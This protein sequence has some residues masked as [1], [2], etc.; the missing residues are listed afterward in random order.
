MVRAGVRDGLA[1]REACLAVAART[2]VPPKTL[3][4]W[5]RDARWADEAPGRRVG[6]DRALLAPVAPRHAP[7]VTRAVAALALLLLGADTALKASL[8]TGSVAAFALLPAWFPQL[9][10]YPGAR[11]VLLVTVAAA[12]SGTVLAVFASD[13]HEVVA[14][15]GYG[16]VLRLFSIAAGL[17]VV[18]W[19]R[20]FLRLET[21]VLLY[22]TGSL[23]SGVLDIPGS[24]N[25]WKYQL[26]LPV[27]LIVLSLLQRLRSRLPSVAALLVLTLLLLGG[28]SAANDYR[29]FF[30]FTLLT[31]VLVTWQALRSTGGRVP[32][33]GFRAWTTSVLLVAGIVY[34]LYATV[35]SLLLS[36]ALGSELQA[37]SRVQVE[38]GGSLI[39]G[40]RPEWSATRVLMADSPGGYGV[41]VVPASRD[42]LLGKTGLATVGISPDN[43]YVDNYMFGG[44]FRLHSIVADCWANFGLVGLALTALVGFLLLNGLASALIE[45]RAQPVTVLLCLLALWDLAFGPI[46]SDLG[47]VYLALAVVLQP[48]SPGFLGSRTTSAPASVPDS[49]AATTR[50]LP[51][52]RRNPPRRAT[53]PA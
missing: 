3:H 15:N 52:S 44:Q 17:G 36:G 31:G 43:G 4:G 9:R 1:E 18:L 7:A 27:T 22:G 41:G 49:T 28:V 26:A 6:A 33:R 42:V 13:T 23:M 29:S 45:R 16:M 19:A 38:S 51:S 5:L 37:R 48:R 47:E 21:V 46:H 8:T 50:R 30:G 39:A 10:R 32:K 20:R 12:V 24:Q 25:P 11:A 2:G 40:G 34:A 53:S 35:T 14:R